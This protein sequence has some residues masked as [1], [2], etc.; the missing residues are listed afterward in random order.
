MPDTSN[1]EPGIT[2]AELLG[3]FLAA[4]PPAYDIGTEPAEAPAPRPR[5]RRAP[6][7]DRRKLVPFLAAAK[8]GV[9]DA[10]LARA[11][12][13]T[14]SQVKGWRRRLG[15][16]RKP[17]TTTMARLHGGLLTAPELARMLRDHDRT[18]GTQP[19]PAVRIPYEEL[20]PLLE[21]HDLDFRGL[22]E[23][24]FTERTSTEFRRRASR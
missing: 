5:R 15:L 17:G 16:T 21:R 22:R 24:Q 13:V 20:A 4:E 9:P 10:D 14:V 12:G 3:L 8:A 11:A 1:S 19:P 23:T 7:L 6:P 18:D 2:V